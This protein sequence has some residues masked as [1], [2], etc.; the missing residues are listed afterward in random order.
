MNKSKQ[1]PFKAIV[2]L[3]CLISIGAFGQKQTKTFNE[4]FTVANESVLDINTS[5]TDIEFETWNKDQLVIEATIE[6]EGATAEEAKDYF[7]NSGFEI[8]GNS[9]KV[10][11]K[12]GAENTWFLRNAVIDAQNLVFEIPE[13]PE[14]P[15]MDSFIFD[16]DFEELQDMPEFPMNNALEF[17]HEAFEKDGE[18]Y[19][20]KWQKDFA[21]GY[22]KEH[23]KELEE[24]G[25]RMEVRQLEMEEKREKMAVKRAEMQEKREEMHEKRTE[26]HE[27]REEAHEKR[28]EK[29]AVAQKL[30]IEAQADRQERLIQIRQHGKANID[31]TNIFIMDNH[32][33]PNIFYSSSK[34]AK[35][36]Y[37]V[38]KTIKIKMP[39]SMK[40][41]MNVRHGEVKLAENTKNINATLSHA[42]LW[43]TTIDGDKTIINASYS[44]VSV[45]HWNYGQ[46]R[47]NYSK[48]VDLKKV[49]NL[50]LN[51]TS[52]DITIDNLLVSA[53]IK[54]DL[55]PIQINSIGKDFEEIDISLQNAELKFKTPEV[56]FTI[57]VNGTS[58]KLTSSSDI[59]LNRTQNG[60][61]IINKGFRGDKNASRS[62]VIH[63]KYSDVVLE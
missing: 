43:A 34:G 30:R 35:K 49:M 24:W 59:T 56:P 14:I 12:T 13:M 47:A 21:K 41:N 42:S 54:N 9:K 8:L 19:L 55:G 23:I 57:Y 36:N 37:K 62:I 7:K 53:Y 58:S 52:S 29:M 20:K 48:N 32:N 40:I 60:N 18:K 61:T 39:K 6:L 25:K 28:V 33:K 22:D 38:K 15:E 63:S 45:Q 1:T 17:D 50:R 10:T 44:P 31:S 26:M 5:H 3:L 27:K 16:F 11:I 51:A 46:L 4:T 2:L